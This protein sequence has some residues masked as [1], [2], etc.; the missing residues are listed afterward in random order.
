MMASCFSV[1]STKGGGGKTTCVANVGAYLADLGLSVLLIDLDVTQPTLSSYYPLRDPASGGIFELIA[2]GKTTDVISKT[3]IDNLDVIIA[4]DSYGQLQSL[5]LNSADGRF[6]LRQLLPKIAAGYD[7]VL[8][9]T[10]GSRSV[11]VEMS[12]LAADHCITPIPPEMLSARE[13][14]RGT[15][16]LFQSLHPLTVQ[17]LTIPGL[18]AYINRVGYDTDAT[19]IT[20]MLRAQLDSD[21]AGQLGVRLAQTPIHDLAVYRE[22]ATRQVP[23]HRHELKRPYGRKAPSAY[24][25]ISALSQELFPAAFFATTE[26]ANG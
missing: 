2:Q 15:L 14:V 21:Q 20:N 8:I 1:V 4:N 17:G 12:I 22:A 6:R 26:V 13:F 7:I 23:A 11:L 19:Q 25:T 9:D 18:T 3:T 24:E 16:A 10:Q 5:I